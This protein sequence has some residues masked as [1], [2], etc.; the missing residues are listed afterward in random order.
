MKRYLCPHCYGRGGYY[1]PVY[2]N[3]VKVDEK[4]YSCP[5]CKDGKVKNYL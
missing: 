1:V 3:G 2:R 5:K 4:W